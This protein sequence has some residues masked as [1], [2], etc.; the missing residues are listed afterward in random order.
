VE[1]ALTALSGFDSAADPL[2]HI[3][4]YIVERNH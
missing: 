2:R 4:R 1:R 3:A